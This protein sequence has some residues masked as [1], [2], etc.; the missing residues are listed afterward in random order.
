MSTAPTPAEA[1]AALLARGEARPAL[2]LCLQALRRA[3][4]DRPLLSLLVR[5]ALAAGEPDGGLALLEQLVPATGQDPG[6]SEAYGSLLALAGRTARIKDFRTVAEAVDS[7]NGPACRVM[8]GVHA[9]LGEGDA[10]A[11]YRGLAGWLEAAAALPDRPDTVPPVAL[12]PAEADVPPVAEP[13]LVC[14]VAHHVTPRIRKLA[15]GLRARGLRVHLVIDGL[16]PPSPTDDQ[17]YDPREFDGLT[18]APG[19]L[20]L[21]RL[22]RARAPLAV[23]VF[24]HNYD[25]WDGAMTA[26][27]LGRPNT[28][29][30]PYDPFHPSIAPQRF[31]GPGEDKDRNRR[32]LKLQRLV[33]DNAP[34]L[35]LRFLYPHL[36]RSRLADRPRRRLY[37]PDMAWGRTPTARKLSADDGMLHVVHGGS[38]QPERTHGTP[39]SGLL[40]LAERAEDFGVHLHLYAVP[41]GRA[42]AG[43]GL[44]LRDYQAVAARSA[45][46][47]LHDPLPY[48]QWLDALARYDLGIMAIHPPDTDIFVDIPRPREPRGLWGN[49]IGDYLDAGLYTVCSW[50]SLVMG[51]LVERYGVGQRATCEEV[52]TRAFWDDLKA[53]L[54]GGDG[55]DLSRGVAALS[56]DRHAE[57]LAAF[58]RTLT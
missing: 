13:D 50:R 36:T 29:I 57:R 35:C 2:G 40:W 24:C 5:A 27:L 10:V 38:F 4:T 58:Y 49:K 20:A 30:D 15:H 55:V 43:G 21:W 34:A 18:H 39:F 42:T 6:V 52:V 45:H 19:P 46:M 56:V 26:L 16:M 48:D 31:D 12:P 32:I 47:H 11:L 37:F 7:L 41:D 14:F 1:I 8:A 28:V 9:A 44:D 51:W 23:H 25:N 22:L 33:Y 3:P 54:L 17:G 53:R